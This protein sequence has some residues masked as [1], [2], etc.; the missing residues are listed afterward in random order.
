MAIFI[1]RMSKK[2][3]EFDFGANLLMFLM[4]ISINADTRNKTELQYQLKGYDMDW[5]GTGKTYQD[6]INEAFAQIE[7]L[8]GYKREQFIVTK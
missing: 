6:A 3:E 8:T 1:T 2:V 4:D 5:R 7:L